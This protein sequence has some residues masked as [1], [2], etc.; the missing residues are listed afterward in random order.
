MGLDLA[1]DLLFL[2]G[3]RHGCI[4]AQARDPFQRGLPTPG[5]VDQSDGVTGMP[6]SAADR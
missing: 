6:P 3:E 1:E 5:G 4:L 2:I